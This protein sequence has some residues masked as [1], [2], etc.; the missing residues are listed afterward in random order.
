MASH[1]IPGAAHGSAAAASTVIAGKAMPAAPRQLEILKHVVDAT[2]PSVF[3]SRRSK[4]AWI[5][6]TNRVESKV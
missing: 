4:G 5:S 3:L 6:S 1:R 2:A